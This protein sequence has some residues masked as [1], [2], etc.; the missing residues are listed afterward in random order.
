MMSDSPQTFAAPA[1]A[2]GRS[3]LAV[4]RVC[5]PRVTEMVRAATGRLP[6]PRRATALTYRGA[7]GAVIDRLICTYYPAD[8]SPLGRDLA[9]WSCHGNPLIV[10]ALLDDLLARG[11]RLAEA[12]EFTRTA[13]EEGK[14]DL[15]QAEAVADLV[16]SRSEAGLRMA[17]AQ[18]GGALRERAEGLRERLYHWMARVEVYLDF[19]EDDL[20]PEESAAVARGLRELG[21]D[22]ERLG[23]G[24]N[25]RR[26]I[27]E[28][29]RTL[30]LG[31]PNA[32][33]SSLMNRLLREER[34]LVSP[35]PGTTRDFI[36]EGFHLG[37]W[38]IQLVD[39]AG[40]RESASG[41]ERE[42]MDRVRYL[43]G[44]ADFV[45]LVLDQS[46]PLPSFP[47]WF[48]ELGSGER[49]LI[50]ENKA[51]L[52]RRLTLPETWESAARARVSVLT[53]EGWEAFLRL[54][55]ERLGATIGD[56]EEEQ[57]LSNERHRRIFATAAGHLEAAL[58]ELDG[59][60]PMLVA[61]ELR[62]GAESLASLWGGF[63]NETMLDELFACFCI[64]K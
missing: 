49:L 21:A 2:P 28:G 64:G 26:E 39:T 22:L 44:E 57:W 24:A 29:V 14:L 48:Q 4:V 61:T 17:Q 36:R 19:P 43:G 11:A 20:P 52:P 16:R 6:P 10:Q 15:A 54:W 45:L 8:R 46:E 51:D 9:E 31:A 50:L 55:Q 42:G 1:T 34:V 32:G 7:G 53:G 33:K 30:I 56:L 5:G 37:P 35:E 23:G 38:Y 63:D 25:R 62:L 41:L 40:V 3:A 60:E 47:E 58:R 12:G 18:L 27:L 59:G 13:F